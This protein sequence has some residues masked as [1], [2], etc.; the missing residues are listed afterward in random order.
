MVRPLYGTLPLS[1]A[2]PPVEGD[3]SR[4]VSPVGPACVGGIV[5]GGTANG[6]GT[7]PDAVWK[8]FAPQT[9]VMQWIP[10]WTGRANAFPGMYEERSSACPP[11]MG[12]FVMRHPPTGAN[13]LGPKMGGCLRRNSTGQSGG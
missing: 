6:P 5:Q 13:A 12:R 10:A 11:L 9:K 1:G 2:R 7:V 3:G 4:P 8:W